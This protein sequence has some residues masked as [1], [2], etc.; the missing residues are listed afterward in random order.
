MGNDKE[1]LISIGQ[2]TTTH[3]VYGELRVLP[4]TDFPERF[5]RLQQVVASLNGEQISLEVESAR[6]FKQFVLLKFVG[7]NDC[8]QAIK[9]KN[10]LLQV[11]SS[12]LMPLPEGHYYI[13]QIVGLSVYTVDGR[14]LGRIKEVFRTGSNDVYQVVGEQSKEV[15]VP[16][17]REVV[18][19]IDLEQ[20]RV[21]IRPLP[22]M[23]E[24]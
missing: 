20:Q 17:L 8:E 23:L 2:V 6:T 19:Q 3:G 14:Y 16:A 21:I 9:L 15:L 11:P 24:I 5:S 22:G 7:I 12:E 18:E 13:F 4:L 1:K 10:A